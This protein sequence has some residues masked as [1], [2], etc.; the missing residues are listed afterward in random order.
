[1][2]MDAELKSENVS[3]KFDRK[4]FDSEERSMWIGSGSFGGKA[5]G[6]A[7]IDNVLTTEFKHDLFEGITVD[8][9]AF[10]V[11]RTDV[12][13][14]FL[15]QNGLEELA[16]S[17]RSDDFIAHEFQKASLPVEIVGDLRSLIAQVHTPLAVRSSSLLEDALFQPFAGIYN[18]KMIPNNQ[19]S[20]DERFRKLTEAIKLV[21]ASTFSSSARDYVKATGRA[22]QDEKMAVIIQEVIGKRFGERFYPQ[23]SG[24]ARSYNFYPT[25]RAKPEDGVVSL[26]L[27]LG[28]TIVDGGKCWTYSPKS[29]SATPPYS[30][31]DEL[32]EQ[33]QSRFWAVNMGKPPAYDPIHETEYLSELQLSDAETDGALRNIASTYDS[34]SDRV[35]P[36]L[37]AQGPRIL[38]FAGTLVLKAIPLND[39]VQHML[40][41]S[42]RALNAPVEIEFAATYDPDRVGFLQ[43]RPMVVSDEKVDIQDSELMD[44]HLLVASERV[45]GN[46]VVS[47]IRDVVYVKPDVF[48]AKHTPAIAAELE[49]INRKLLEEGRPYLLVGFGR[50]GSSDPWLGIPVN[51][52]GVCGAKVIVEATLP[53]MDIELSQGSHFFHNLTSFKV[54]YF[55]VP[56]SGPYQIRWEWLDRQEIK[57]DLR[58]VRHVQ[59]SSALQVK[60][61]GRHGRGIISFT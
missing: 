22:P 51:W 16:Y 8:I 2:T 46:G 44:D 31:I 20:A 5:Q 10:T 45:L 54:S 32:M 6:L 7:S 24:V 36:G 56:H 41:M 4:F 60:V 27:G 3:H 38:N 43:V 58:F 33:T 57:T 19:P 48:E 53:K 18:T 30:S 11:L 15:R 26:A 49:K 28:K 42:Q 34:R 37:S 1:M 35:S 17:G 9:P 25:G 13:D 61:D 40:S 59:P 23:V 14:A 55:C 29:P 47:G 50:W 12:F 39:I 52:G 21:Y